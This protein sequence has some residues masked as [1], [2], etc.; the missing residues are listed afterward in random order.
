MHLEAFILIQ[1]VF[2]SI[3]YFSLGYVSTGVLRILSK[4]S[5]RHAI[6]LE[7]L[8]IGHLH[9]IRCRDLTWHFFV[10]CLQKD[11]TQPM[12]WIYWRSLCH[13]VCIHAYTK[14]TFIS[15][16]FVFSYICNCKIWKYMMAFFTIMIDFSPSMHGCMNACIHVIYIGRQ[17]KRR[18]EG[19]IRSC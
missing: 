7:P 9:C 10:V 5:R 2:R 14:H 6:L 19:E 1:K 12:W 17:R 13:K 3:Y 18:C 15:L 4:L 8:Q 11:S 16:Q